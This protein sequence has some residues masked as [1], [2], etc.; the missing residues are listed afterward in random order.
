MDLALQFSAIIH[1]SSKGGIAESAVDLRAGEFPVAKCVEKRLI[2][3][4]DF[5]TFAQKN[6]DVCRYLPR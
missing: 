4:N 5:R 3:H 2:Y 6:N 1:H